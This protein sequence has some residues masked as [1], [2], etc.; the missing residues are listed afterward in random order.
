[1]TVWVGDAIDY[2]GP[3]QRSGV[4]GHG[5]I[6]TGPA[7]YT[8]AGRWIAMTGSDGQLTGLVYDEDGWSAYAHGI[9]VMSQ[10]RVTI[11][12]GATFVLRRRIVAAAAGRDGDPWAPLARL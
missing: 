5:T 11:A 2:D 9:W 12:A 10:R 1:M 6:T 3:G 7:D 8:P 4:A